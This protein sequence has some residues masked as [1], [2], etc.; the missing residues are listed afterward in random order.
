MPALGRSLKINRVRSSVGDNPRIE[1]GGRPLRAASSKSP[2][3]RETVLSRV[4]GMP[5]KKKTRKS[6]AA[7]NR[8]KDDV[9]EAP[10]DVSGDTTG[11]PV[12]EGTTQPV[13]NATV[14]KENKEAQ[15]K[16]KKTKGRNFT[17]ED[18][19]YLAKAYINATCDS[20]NGAH[21]SGTVF[22]KKVHVAYGNLW[23]DSGCDVY[24]E[25]DAESLQNRF[26]KRLQGPTMKFNAIYLNLKKKNISGKTE[27]D[28]ITDSHHIYKA[29]EEKTFTHEHFWRTIRD[30]LPKY[31]DNTSDEPTMKSTT[32][33]T[34]GRVVAH[35]DQDKQQFNVLAGGQASSFDKPLGS[36]KAKQMKRDSDS[37]QYLAKT[38]NQN[39]TGL[40][41]LTQNIA[42]SI[43][44]D[45]TQAKYKGH[46]DIAR[47]C[48]EIG[49]IERMNSELE[50]AQKCLEVPTPVVPTFVQA[51]SANSSS[52]SSRTGDAV[53]HPTDGLE[54]LGR[55]S[56]VQ[57]P[58]VDPNV[59][60]KRGACALEDPLCSDPEDDALLKRNLD[61]PKQNQQQ[62][63]TD[64]ADDVHSSTDDTSPEMTKDSQ[65]NMV[66]TEVSQSQEMYPGG[67]TDHQVCEGNQRQIFNDIRSTIQDAETQVT[68][69]EYRR[70]QEAS[71]RIL[72]G[73]KF[74]EAR[75]ALERDDK[76]DA[77][78]E[79]ETDDEVAASAV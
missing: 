74:K 3:F 79:S 29:Q 16:M 34:G 73:S 11:A 70:F 47:F 20:A 75:E 56:Q 21:Q 24:V 4:E 69:E 63:S 65:G 15:E 37:I 62:H 12:D 2:Y 68:E 78:S 14:K 17:R 6:G 22:W 49:D 61:P 77:S 58:L 59:G 44:V 76:I 64:D 28:L 35:S 72:L 51:S 19:I 32:M 23:D 57:T 18:D 31:S 67:L 60:I 41:S 45:T 1:P 71:R 25:R 54:L 30:A 13:A 50:K 27:E 66:P 52:I 42:T 43:S 33:S 46:L 40:L 39:F 36:K 10:P 5:P 55:L 26:Q 53:G 38:M 8:R 7:T 48:Q 9:G